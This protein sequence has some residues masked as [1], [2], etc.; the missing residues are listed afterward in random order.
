MKNVLVTCALFS[1][2]GCTSGIEIVNQGD[3]Y[4]SSGAYPCSTETSPCVYSTATAVNEWFAAYPRPGFVFAGWR[5]CPNPTGTAC[6]VSLSQE[7]VDAHRGETWPNLVAL[8]APT[9][10]VPVKV[11]SCTVG[12]NMSYDALCSPHVGRVLY[13]NKIDNNPGYPDYQ[14]S[15]LQIVGFDSVI[16]TGGYA[17][18]YRADLGD[19]SSDGLYLGGPH[20]TASD[21]SI[22]KTS[23]AYPCQGLDGCMI[24]IGADAL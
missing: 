16:Y 15:Y 1:L 14:P 13:I 9:G 18:I 7:T 24:T 10:S 4:S 12:P 2:F 22:Y 3:V 8:F 11:K 20:P 17:G 19:P 21:V 23:A 6:H 5:N